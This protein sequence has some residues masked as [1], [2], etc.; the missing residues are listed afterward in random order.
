MARNLP[1]APVAA[2]E[3]ASDSEE[4]ARRMAILADANPK[5]DRTPEIRIQDAGAGDRTA[6][7]RKV[8][9]AR[10]A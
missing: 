7:R 8:F 9:L 5:A 4:L 3:I 1:F 10:F 2:L 6:Q